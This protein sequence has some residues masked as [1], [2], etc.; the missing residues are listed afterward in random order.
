MSPII[1]TSASDLRGLIGEDT[2]ATISGPA[3]TRRP[4][5]SGAR[6]KAW[7][8]DVAFHIRQLGV[9]PA[10]DA[11][12]AMWIVEAPW[13]HPVGHSYAVILVHLR[14]MP[15]GRK[16]LRCNPLGTHEI[17]VWALDPEADRNGM[18]DNPNTGVQS[19]ALHPINYAG[20]FVEVEDSLAIERVR[21]S[22]QAICDGKL[23]PDTDARWDW[24]KLYGDWMFKDRPGGTRMEKR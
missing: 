24:A 8:I 2:V 23:S 17:W 14:D 11:T 20:Q 21:A 6:G 18:L 13:A 3:V 15:D 1:S 7:A 5:V 22:V 16:T 12:L 4:D 10:Q 9:D 19:F